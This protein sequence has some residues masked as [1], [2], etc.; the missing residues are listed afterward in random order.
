MQGVEYP[1][2]RSPVQ[3]VSLDC[4]SVK[5]REQA[6]SCR[7]F[8]HSNIRLDVEEKLTIYYDVAMKHI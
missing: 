6:F 1:Q 3:K 8:E 4:A 5:T 7:V 2:T